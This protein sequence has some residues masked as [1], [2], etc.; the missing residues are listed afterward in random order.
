M[1]QAPVEAVAE[2][3]ENEDMEVLAVKVLEVRSGCLFGIMA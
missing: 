1:A 2:K 3:V